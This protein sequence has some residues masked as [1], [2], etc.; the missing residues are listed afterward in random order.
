MAYKNR[1]FRPRRDEQDI[2]QWCQHHERAGRLHEAFAEAI[3]LHIRYHSEQAVAPPRAERREGAG[4]AQAALAPEAFR[5][6][7]QEIVRNSGDTLDRGTLKAAFREIL[8]ELVSLLV[9]E[10]ARRLVIAGPNASEVSASEEE[11]Q[12]L[13]EAF[14]DERM[15]DDD[16][17]D[18]E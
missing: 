11:A 3:R 13:R 5:E 6:I 14:A 12:K 10:L 1:G 7:L 4:A 2:E 16:D 17:E 15:F 8:P 18:D 9:P